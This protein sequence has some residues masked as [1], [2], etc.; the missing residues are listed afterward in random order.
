LTVLVTAGLVGA[1]LAP[2]HAMPR[3]GSAPHAPSTGAPS[4]GHSQLTT[5]TG[6][7]REGRGAPE[8]QAASSASTSINVASGLCMDDP[9][10]QTTTG[11][12]LNQLTCNGGTNQSW[13]F[14]PVS[15]ATSTYS[16]TSFAG[17]CVDVSGRST[18]DNA[19]VIQW[20]CN[21]QTNQQFQAQPVAVSG[22]SNTFNLI[23]VHS[24]KC[25]VP[26]G[27]STASNALLVQLPCSTAGTRVW[28]VPGI[29]SGGG[30]TGFQ[31]LP[32][33]APN[34]CHSSTLPKSYGTNFP[35][36]ADPN[37]QGFANDTAIGWDGNY[38]P[39]FEFLSGSFFARGVPTTY[40]SGS[41]S[42]CGGMYT[43]SAYDF[44]GAPGPGS[45]QWT[46]DNGY[47]PAMTTTRTVGSVVISIKDFADKVTI[48]GNPFMLVYARVAVTNNGTAA[49]TV[50]PGGS[51]PNLIQ[52]TSS[53]LNVVQP[54]QTNDNDFVVAVDNFGTG[55]ALPTG[56]ALSASAPSFDS[57][58]TAMANYWNGRVAETPS[59]QL[60][61]LALPNTGGL[62]NPGAA[63]SNAFKA[64]TIYNLIM[65][66]GEAQFSAANN[67]AWVLNH[68]VPG[69]LQARFDSGDFHDAQNLL[70][71]ARIS[72]SPSFSEV[73]ANWYWDGV[74]KTVGTWAD[75]L[76]L[77]GDT[78]FV[79]Q[80]FHDDAS[81]SSPWGPSLFTMMHSLYQSQLA[82]DGTLVAN[83]DND[84]NGRWLFSNF[85]ALEALA[86]YK[87]IATRLGMTSEA[88]YADGAY[89]S[90]L[91]AL[92]T[93]VGNDES[94]NGFSY[95]PC[96][97]NQ[98]NSAN[99]C[100][101]FN[102]ANWA[103][104]GWVGQDQWSTM[105]MGGTLTGLIGDPGQIDRMYQTGFARLAANNL[106]Y[107]TFG[108]FTG[109]S[110]A[111]NTAYSNDGLYSSN[112]R[113]LP[114]TSYA[115]QIETTTGG[116]NAW[117]E[118]NGSGPN[119]NNPW[120][121]NHAPPE[122]GACPYA[123]PISG[124]QLG[125]LQAIAAT[126]LTASGTGPYT[127][128]QPLYIG[129][130]IPNTWIAAGQT[131]AVSNLSSAYNIGSGSRSTYGISIAVT[132]PAS[133]RVVAV[134]LTGT[135]PSGPVNIQLP[136]F[137]TT[138]VNSVTGGTYNA[139]THTV[140][141]TS[142]ATQITITLAS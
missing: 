28:Q 40:T 129:R 36:P 73:G 68:D 107:P 57:A 52:L 2:A 19:Q 141:A 10:S 118:A 29:T 7:S 34:A 15:G 89:T 96:T 72:E 26:A 20:T 46:E 110:T 48:G 131:I 3:G 22:Q 98:P 66:V 43:F 83:N 105:L 142:G 74:W 126:G 4:T 50:P 86:S 31:G 65:Q 115:W 58:Y 140:T 35:V 125:L 97:V 109:Y 101:T 45:V 108:A 94:A 71:T 106:P 88:Q 116:P 136:V 47:L 84:S 77:T 117:W 78:A 5:G 59:F 30:S 104:P 112:Y 17:L 18:A 63:L 33:V 39:V 70:L 80:F 79:S 139:T 124:Q 82:S 95:L 12:Q 13:T 69:E 90:L 138:G 100:G 53:S 56:A 67:Y 137:L 21:G 102:D 119:P 6:Q 92:N 111:Y 1:G 37:G 25:I 132:K 54:G 85:S 75:Y 114:I 127:Y 9:N 121:G 14:T 61:N 11:V 41:T 8:A 133:T 99:R 23:A 87:Y 122:F 55:A 64:G 113:D 51:G 91:N 76:R 135:P 44:G 49:V 24:G 103:S 60:P 38:W 120:A 130:G 42:Y 27:D 123:W 32:N 134:T 81:G 93:V 128:T 16:I 62:A